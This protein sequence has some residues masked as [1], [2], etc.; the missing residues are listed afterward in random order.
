MTAVGLLLSVPA[1]TAPQGP[2]IV[3]DPDPS[4]KIPAIEQAVHDKDQSALP[5]LVRDLDSDDPAVRFYA[6]QGLRRLTGQDLGYAYYLDQDQR[7]AAVR[8]WQQWLAAHA[9]ATRP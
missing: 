5:Q 4:V 1:C 8:Q 6:I 7:Q 2:R 3:S 9:P